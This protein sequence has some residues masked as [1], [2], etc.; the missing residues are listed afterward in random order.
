MLIRHDVNVDQPASSCWRELLEPPSHWLP[1][2]AGEEVGERRFRARVGFRAPASRITKQVE[3]TVG[4]AAQEG[5]W[6]SIPV[7]WRATGPSQ[8]FPVMEGKLTVQPLGPHSAKLIFGGTYQPP[9]GAVRR[10]IDDVFMHNVADATVKDFLRSV[11]K[12]LSE[13]AASRRA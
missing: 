1:A 12:R 4:G 13:L 7:G 10:Q 2:S 9:L 11:A 6:L 5:D 3:L 8:L